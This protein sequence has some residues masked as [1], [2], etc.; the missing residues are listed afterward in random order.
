MFPARS[1]WVDRGNRRLEDR[2]RMVVLSLPTAGRIVKSNDLGSSQYDYR[3]AMLEGGAFR[4]V[5][6]G[7]GTVGH[8][9]TPSIFCYF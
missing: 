4:L 6:R 3:L 8:G 9:A 1:L 7:Q 5:R 2:Q